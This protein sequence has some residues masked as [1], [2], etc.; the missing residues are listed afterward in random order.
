MRIIV[1]RVL[2]IFCAMKISA[3]FDVQAALPQ[4]VASGSFGARRAT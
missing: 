1:S 2:K 3:H 4:Y